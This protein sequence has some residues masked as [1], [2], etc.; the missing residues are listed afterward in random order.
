MSLCLCRLDPRIPIHLL[1]PD[2][3][4]YIVPFY[5]QFYYGGMRINQYQFEERKVIYL[6]TCL[7]PFWRLEKRKKERK[8]KENIHRCISFCLSIGVSNRRPT[9]VWTPQPSG[10]QESGLL[11]WLF[12]TLLLPRIGFL[13]FLGSGPNRRQSPVEWGDFPPIRSSICSSVRL[14][15]FCR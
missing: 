8:R 4:R 10:S 5:V 13:A 3:P 15:C 9:S 14:G 7:W 1:C 11:E 12:S 2:S 6:D